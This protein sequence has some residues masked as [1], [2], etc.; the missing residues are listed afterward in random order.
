MDYTISNTQMILLSIV[1]LWDLIWKGLAL[2]RASQLGQHSWF[3]VL[4]VLNTVGVL[5]IAYLL[6]HKSLDGEDVR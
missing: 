4:L 5:P 3:I 2:W 1:I 6:T